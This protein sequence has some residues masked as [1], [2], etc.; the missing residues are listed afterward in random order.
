MSK[1]RPEAHE[2]RVGQ[3]IYVVNSNLAKIRPRRF[4]PI[5]QVFIGRNHGGVPVCDKRVNVASRSYV[6]DML[7]HWYMIGAVYWSSKKAERAARAFGWG[8]P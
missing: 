7:E 3:T 6:K 1:T 4:Y 5:V 2:I 8:R